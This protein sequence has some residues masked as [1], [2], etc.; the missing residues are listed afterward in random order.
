VMESD[1]VP[2]ELANG[3]V[4]ELSASVFTEDL[5]RGLS[6]ARNIEAGRV[7]VFLLDS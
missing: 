4:H 2:I 7:R 6:V 1:K 5:R 3:T